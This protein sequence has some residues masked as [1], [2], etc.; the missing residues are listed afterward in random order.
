MIR[1]GFAALGV[2]WRRVVRGAS[3]FRNDPKLRD[4]LQ[5]TTKQAERARWRVGRLEQRI[6]DVRTANA[7]A[8]ARIEDN[9]ELYIDLLKRAL[10]HT[11]Y[12]PLDIGARSAYAQRTFDEE[13][14]RA[15]GRDWPRSAQTMVGIKRLDNVQNCV[16]TVLRER[17]PGDFIETGVWRGGTVIF[18]RGLL[19]AWG[20]PPDRIVFVADSFQGLPAPNEQAY[21]ADA[22]SQLHT[23]KSLAVPRAEVER[24]FELYGLLD[25]RVRFLEGW[26]KDTL[27][28]VRD[29]TW[30]VIRLDGDMYESTLDGLVNLYPQLAVGGFLIIDDYHAHAACRLAVTDYRKEHGI[31]EPIK[32]VDWACVYWRRER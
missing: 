31:E 27:P 30:A 9:R 6:A 3:R 28:T 5:K 23:A 13:Q 8:F 32:T 10:M 11:L 22:G 7:Q 26:F 16:E 29:R 2:Q 1:R 25:D 15:E 19:R 21:P 24:N 14:T 20:D 4:R 17:I 12:R 18:M